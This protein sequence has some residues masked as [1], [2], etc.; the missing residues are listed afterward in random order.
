MSR[1]HG[2]EVQSGTE[3][4]WEWL[5]GIPDPEMPYVSIV[6]LGIVRDVRW[7]DDALRVVV[8]PTY[9]G[10]PAKAQIDSNIRQTLQDRGVEAVRLETRL[11]PAWSTDWLSESG[12]SKLRA[13]GIAPPLPAEPGWQRLRFVAAAAP[14]VPCPRCGSDATRPQGE[15][16][17][18]ACK[19]LYQCDACRNPFEHF[20]SL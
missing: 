19:S 12:R 11:H 8:T 7:E 6:D 18:T 13:A 9:S 1:V 5:A 10:C 15:F 16:G 14:R 17:G 4:V 20:K 2:L 3:R